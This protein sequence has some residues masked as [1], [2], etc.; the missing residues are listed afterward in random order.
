MLLPFQP[1][2]VGVDRE[3]TV[4]TAAQVCQGPESA[5]SD[6]AFERDCCGQGVQLHRLIVEFYL[7]QVLEAGLLQALF[8]D[9]RVRSDPE[10]ALGIGAAGG[11]ASAASELGV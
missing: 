4:G 8:G 6:V 9:L 11:P 7:P 10:G 5:V 3:D 1:S 2:Q